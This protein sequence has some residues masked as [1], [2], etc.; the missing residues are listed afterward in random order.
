M[1]CYKIVKDGYIL[2]VG[3]GYGGTEITS[4]EYNAIL[5]VILSKPEP[6]AGYDYR[7]TEGLEWEQFE[8]PVVDTSDEEIS[9]SEALGIIAG[10][11][12]A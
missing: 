2:V 3:E 11:E 6:P 10:G 7:L 9:D 5:E 1:H 12:G 8:I 4:E